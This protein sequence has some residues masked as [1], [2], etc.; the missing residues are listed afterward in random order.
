MS[1]DDFINS[2]PDI[3]QDT[4]SISEAW[5]GAIKEALQLIQSEIDTLK[6]NKLD[7]HATGAFGCY[8]AVEELFE[9][10]GLKEELG[11]FAEKVK[12]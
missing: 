10:Y 1:L 9:T 11:E 2:F 8:N 12:K 5:N 4:I 3:E 6:R 7:N